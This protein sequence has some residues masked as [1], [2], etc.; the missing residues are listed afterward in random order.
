MF[1]RRRSS[2]AMVHPEVRNIE[3]SEL[4]EMLLWKLITPKMSSRQAKQVD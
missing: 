1:I 2:E 4:N 3:R